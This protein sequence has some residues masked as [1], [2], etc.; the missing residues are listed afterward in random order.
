MIVVSAGM[1][2]SGT[3]WY[4]DMCQDLAVA[5]GWSK[6]LEMRERHN[7]DFLTYPRCNL[8]RLYA[9]YMQRLDE[10]GR[11]GENF[12][13]KT[14]RRPSRALRKLLETGRFKATYIYRDLRDVILSGLEDGA[15]MRANGEL[16]RFF[17]IGP[18]RSFARLHTVKGGIMWVRW[19][20]LPRWEAWMR[21]PGVLTTR[22]E[23]LQ[24][25]AAGELR[26]FASHVGLEVQDSQIQEVVDRYRRD[27]VERGEIAK[28]VPLNKGIV[29]RF[30]EVWSPEE[31]ALCARRLGRYLERMG[32]TV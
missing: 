16:S 32:Y 26:R 19:Q 31:Q 17:W 15:K 3:R 28:P 23:D 7:L 11:Q 18:Y 27:R 5:A 29:G 13:V 24:R 9:R 25:D 8:P 14:H 20:L 4:F 12:M 21:C 1:Q 30:A 2:R 6:S 10:V 22:Y